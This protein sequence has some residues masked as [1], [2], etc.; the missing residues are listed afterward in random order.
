[1]QLFHSAKF[2]LS[3]LRL[4]PF[5]SCTTACHKIYLAPPNLLSLQLDLF[6]FEIWQSKKANQDQLW[7]QKKPYNQIFLPFSHICQFQSVYF[8]KK[9]INHFSKS[10]TKFFYHSRNCWLNKINFLFWNVL[11]KNQ[12]NNLILT[13]RWAEKTQKLL[14]GRLVLPFSHCVHHL[15]NS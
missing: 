12:T 14:F 11:S 5:K 4:E 7:E 15:V 2:K 9:H 1:M 6:V 10:Y 3:L 8:K 13:G